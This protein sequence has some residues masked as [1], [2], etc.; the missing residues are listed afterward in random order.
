MWG[1]WRE[2]LRGWNGIYVKERTG[3]YRRTSTEEKVCVSMHL[4]R[5]VPRGDSVTSRL[6]LGHPETH[7]LTG[8]GV[9][10]Q[11]GSED[12]LAEGVRRRRQLGLSE[13]IA[14]E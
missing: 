7:K 3:A 6:Q 9:G 12:R 13:S 2:H 1:T 4:Q 11:V 5:L 14:F 8:G 10:E